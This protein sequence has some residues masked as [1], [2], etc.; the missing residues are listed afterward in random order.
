MENTE[1]Y[2]RRTY[3]AINKL[4]NAYKNGY[5][6]R[7]TLEFRKDLMAQALT[8]QTIMQEEQVGILFTATVALL[9]LN[10]ESMERTGKFTTYKANSFTT[11]L[12]DMHLPKKITDK[13]EQ[14][15]SQRVIST[16]FDNWLSILTKIDADKTNFDHLRRVRN[17]LLHS[18]FELEFDPVEL[19]ITHI[20]TKSYYEAEVLDTEF[21]MFVF[22]YFS[23]LEQLGLTENLITFDVSR[24]KMNTRED[25]LKCLYFMTVKKYSYDNLKTLKSDT[26][27]LILKESTHDFIVDTHEFDKKIKSSNNYDN[28][29]VTDEKL[30]NNTIAHV[31]VYIEKNYGDKFFELDVDTQ[32]GIIATYLQYKMNPKREISNWM[33]HFWYLYQNLYNGEFKK[34]FFNGDEFGKES[35][36]PSLMILKAYLIMYRLQHQSFEEIDYSKVNFDINDIKVK[37]NSDNVKVPITSENYFKESF[38]K[39]NASGILSES[40]IWNKIVCEILRNSLAHGNIKTYNDTYSLENLVELKD[41]DPKKGNVRIITMPLTMFDEL[42]NSEAF[43]PKNCKTKE[44][45]KTKT[46]KK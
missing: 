33:M 14:F 15:D 44:K 30:D 2:Y 42:L 10:K 17:G 7:N 13:I 31:F 20:K 38:D 46:L 36:Y 18:N 45:D 1:K 28:F 26:P 5:D 35:C 34:E 4:I 43:L 29:K 39:E 6:E 19:N 3:N 23:N 40:E 27:E 32:T 37:L 24:E 16:D 41:I 9:G 21:Q 11:R 25:L 22:E 12:R 8:N